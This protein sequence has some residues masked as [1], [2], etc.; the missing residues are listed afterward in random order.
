MK[1]TE[2][3]VL[4]AVLV[5]F[6]A[7]FAYANS[8]S[9]TFHWEDEY[10]VKENVHI[11]RLS[12]IPAFF[13]PGYVNV[14][15]S[16]A[17][18]RYRPLRTVTLALD[19]ALWKEDPRGY[20]LTNVLLNAGVAVAFW[21]L[22]L[23]LTGDGFFALLAGLLFAVHPV[24]SESVA[25]VKNRSDIL[26]ALFYFSSAAAFAFYR[27]VNGRRLLA[28]A[29]LLALPAFLAKEMALTLPFAL[30]LL[31]IFSN[32]E[33][34]KDWK[35]GWETVWPFFAMLAAY[36][37]FRE[38]VMTGG[39]GAGPGLLSRSSVMAVTA[40][41]YLKT[42][43]WPMELSLDRAL[44]AS[45][46]AGGQYIMSAVFLLGAP[47]LWLAGKRRGAFWLLLF[48]VLYV[49]VSNLVIIE[50]RPFAEQRM[51]LPSAAFCAFIAWALAELSRAWSRGKL[52]ASGL[53]LALVFSWGCRGFYRNLDWKSETGLWEKTVLSNPSARAYN[54]LAVAL[55]REKRYEES[56]KNAAESLKLDPS[57]VDTYNTLGAAYYD[58]GLYDKSMAAFEKA[59]FFSDGRAYKSLMNL[60]TLYSL[61]GRYNDALG[62][63]MKVAETAPWLDSAHYNMGLTLVKLKREESAAR[64]FGEAISLNPYN[65]QAYLMLGRILDKNKKKDAAAVV[66]SDLLKIEPGNQEAASYVR[67]N[68]TKP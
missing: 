20:H 53:A 22:C 31:L 10:L 9:P 39:G 28:A 30:G 52:V 55:L 35:D 24:H 21:F 50:G 14:Y 11:R 1:T 59:V 58:L 38:I 47:G 32:L 44:P 49:P 60:G 6:A 2:N 45:G 34:G 8:I 64:A 3:K 33:A 62:I 36:L 61:K 23:A 46:A 66:Y 16:G 12:N 25:W 56:V 7:F 57:F 5:F 29:L 26:C 18:K 27:K 54:N 4:C 42:L 65:A 43:I 37:V 13:R 48:W 15:E 41:E 68:L 19:Y 67:A 63:Y 51:Y 40:G 17:G